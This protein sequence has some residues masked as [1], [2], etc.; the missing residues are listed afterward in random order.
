VGST[1]GHGLVFELTPNSDGSWTEH[2]LHAFK[3][4][5]GANPGL[6]SLI[7]DASGNLYGTTVTGGDLN[8]CSTQSQGCGVI[9]ELKPNSNGIW[10]EKV[11][12]AFHGGADGALPLAGLILDSV[13]NL[14]GTTSEGGSTT[15]Q[16]GCG[17]VFRLAPMSGGKWKER[18]LYAFKGAKD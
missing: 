3:G 11:I 13:G 9:F 5:D 15:C 12:Y 2:V 7:F 1:N 10:I 16:L 17:V 8:D 4:T 14:Y 6:G 18:A